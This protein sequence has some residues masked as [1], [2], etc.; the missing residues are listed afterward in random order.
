MTKHLI[1]YVV[2]LVVLA[3]SVPMILGKVPPNY[4]FG[5]RTPKT[6]S[7]PDVWYAANRAAG[8]FMVAAAAISFC[9]NLALWWI[10]PE[11]PLERT[12]SWMTGGTLIPLAIGFL[13]SFIYLRRL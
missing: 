6:L 12:M 13:A 4:F 1:A 8:W 11:W 9:F 5:F 10:F 3:S 7:S 2:P